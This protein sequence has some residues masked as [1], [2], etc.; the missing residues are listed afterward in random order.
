MAPYFAVLPMFSLFFCSSLPPTPLPS[1][2][3]FNLFGLLLLVLI[4]SGA[5][6]HSFLSASW[7]RSVYCLTKCLSDN[8][9]IRLLYSTRKLL[10]MWNRIE[11]IKS[12]W[13]PQKIKSS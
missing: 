6:F 8:P 12:V 7:Q 3:S 2:P 5:T 4:R 1:L 9:I 10:L 13:K 11:P